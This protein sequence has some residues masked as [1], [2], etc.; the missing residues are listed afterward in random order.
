MKPN[1]QVGIIL[2]LIIETQFSS[3]LK[4]GFI[5]SVLEEEIG[6]KNLLAGSSINFVNKVAA[7]KELEISK[8][9]AGHAGNGTSG[10]FPT[11]VNP[12]KRRSISS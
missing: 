6:L 10:C 3:I 7:I 11:T 4:T 1:G 12:M 8:G 2:V 5:H 9:I